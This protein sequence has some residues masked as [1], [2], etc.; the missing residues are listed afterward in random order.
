MGNVLVNI[1]VHYLPKHFSCN[2]DILENVTAT[3]KSLVSSI[4][5]EIGGDEME[6]E[7]EDESEE[8]SEYESEYESEEESGEW[9]RLRKWLSYIR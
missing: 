2:L 5:P 9:R 7:S 6:E 8:E 1:Y 4:I 3:P